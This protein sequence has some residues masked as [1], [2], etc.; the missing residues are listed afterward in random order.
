[1]NRVSGRSRRSDQLC[2]KACLWQMLVAMIACGSVLSVVSS[3]ATSR[4]SQQQ[5][6][7]ETPRSNGGVLFDEPA[8]VGLAR[9]SAALDRLEAKPIS[10]GILESINQ[11]AGDDAD[12][13]VEQLAEA[14]A[15]SSISNGS[16]TGRLTLPKDSG[17]L[18]PLTKMSRFEL[19]EL[20]SSIGLKLRAEMGYV[21][22]SPERISQ[23][24]PPPEG[25]AQAMVLSR[26]EGEGGVSLL[27]LGSARYASQ[28]PQLWAQGVLLAA[29]G[30]V[31]RN[32][33]L[34]LIPAVIESGKKQVEEMRA[35]M[36]NAELERGIVRLS[37]TSTNAAI[38]ALKGLGV[39]TVGTMD[40]IPANLTFDQ[41]PMVAVMP[42]PSP[43]S[44]TLLGDGKVTT[45]AF[46]NSVTTNA[47]KLPDDVDASAGSQLIVLYHPAH[48]EQL[49]LVRSLLDEY[50]D[51]PARL[52]FVEGMVLEISESGLDEL[53]VEWEFK[54]GPINLLLGTLD[55]SI[56]GDTLD[57]DRLNSRDVGF[58]WGL[59]IQ[60]LV[61][62]G[63]A[64]VLSRPS[65]LTMDNRQASIRV[66]EDIP[67]A[68]SQEGTL[69]SNKIAFNFKYIATG[70]LLNIRPRVSSEGDE[71]S[72]LV[73]TIVSATVPG[74]DLEVRSST[75]DLL[76]SAPT[77]STRRVQ[78]YARMDNKTP[79][80]IGGLVSKNKTVT[81][82]K[83]PILGDIPFL[84][85]AFK[86]SKTESEKREVIIVLTPY[87]LPEENRIIT[88]TMPRDE[89]LFDST[90]NRL[91][92][93]A[94]RIRGEDVFDLRFIAENKRL[95][96]YRKLSREVTDSNFRLA[97]AYP[98]SEFTENEIPGSELLV[99][100]MVYELIKRT[101]TDERVSSD[102]M[103]YFEESQA[104]G[105][106]VRF[107]SDLLAKIGDGSNAESFFE[108]NPG[109]A[110]AITFG[111]DRESLDIDRLASEPIPEISLI[112][113]PDRAAWTDLLWELN[114]PFP[115]GTERFTILLQS[116]RDLVRLQRAVMMKLI[117]LLNV[118]DEALNLKSF[119]IGKI[120]H[121]PS[122]DEDKVTVIDA[123]VAR[124][125]YV[126]ELYY[127][128]LVKRIE[129][130]LS[131][132]DRVLRDSEILG[133]LKNPSEIPEPATK[134][135]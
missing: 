125:F 104:E 14:I 75:G 134:E 67:V 92:R 97:D 99:Q 33:D 65:V 102:R 22:A 18:L 85:E 42:S 28:L 86:S 129:E 4:T 51:R 16:N 43:G 120:L 127:S 72:M 118:D 107:L 26:K 23:F 1:M 117:I 111:Y 122:M 10:A 96:L 13:G 66:G 49:S 11:R 132:M 17:V 50:I 83:V 64:E 74:Q 77:I 27:R 60:A 62:E 63:K 30:S 105:Y 115:D 41:L 24:G 116:P 7:L 110:V 113:C 53:G 32:K 2:S 88:R 109:K 20:L 73:D 15:R 76:A 112:D 108:K 128:A 68:T 36:S 81:N 124:N 84:G 34:D 31:Q 94:Y 78:T 8:E 61:S 131:A 103:I 55:P 91:F 12:S 37:Y 38:N 98:F 45:G 9:I 82:Q 5:I 121:V 80:I 40:G 71:I 114:Q 46:G 21:S 89:D 39:S 58:D 29:D 6:T 119:R 54:E 126:S 69:N 106:K 52:I 93:D 44:T 59:R 70:I 130:T 25:V 135:P 123:E 101:K 19:S 57:F 90:E 3:C 133:Y 87:V 79:F 95:S 35:S 56:I 100:R 48:P 47:A